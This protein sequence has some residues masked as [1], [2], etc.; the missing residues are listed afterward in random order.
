[1]TSS[2]P[3][4]PHPLPRSPFVFFPRNK[5]RPRRVLPSRP[6]ARIAG[7]FE[8]FLR[9]RRRDVRKV[10]LSRDKQPI[11][12]DKECLIISS[13]YRRILITD[14]SQQL[15]PNNSQ[16]IV[17][18]ITDVRRVYRCVHVVNFQFMKHFSPRCRYHLKSAGK[19]ERTRRGVENA[20]AKKSLEEI[21]RVGISFPV[22]EKLRRP[23]RLPST[24]L[25]LRLITRGDNG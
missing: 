13:N 1:M 20:S 11:I 5:P 8:S 19:K 17:R 15:K 2:S 25:E 16:L 9:S 10:Q 24:R 21:Q 22:V 7:I 12:D 3:R 18:S 4:L 14:N 6:Q 23:R